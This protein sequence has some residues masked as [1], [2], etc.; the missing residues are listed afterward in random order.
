M[1]VNTRELMNII[2]VLG[3]EEHIRFTVQ[4]SA[5]GALICGA[6]AFVG[7]LLGGP[8]GLPIGGA[9][10][11]LIGMKANSTFRP[12]SD[13][14]R[15]DLSVQQQEELKQRLVGLVRDINVLDAVQ[16]LVLLQT[17]KA[18]MG[19]V[20]RESVNFISQATHAALATS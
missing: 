5:K 18:L 19:V 12:L 3:D 1:V 2:A 6:G 4:S 13:I 7:G 8:V 17:D 15:R 9:I 10:G 20:L 16:L 14:V 11:G